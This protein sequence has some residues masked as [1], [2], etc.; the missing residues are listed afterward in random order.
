MVH[1]GQ[2]KQ[3]DIRGVAEQ[4]FNDGSDSQDE[5]RSEGASQETH[6]QIREEGH[7][8]EVL[9]NEVV[10]EDHEDVDPS[11]PQSGFQEDAPLFA[12]R[13]LVG[14]DHTSHES[15]K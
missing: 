10:R 12:S 4:G 13:D 15:E 9:R 1:V 14:T 11:H 3:L 8:E 5:N 2:F 7:F 6:H